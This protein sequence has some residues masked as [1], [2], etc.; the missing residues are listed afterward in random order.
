MKIKLNIKSII[1]A[2]K[3]LKKPFGKFDLN[4]EEEWITLAYAMVISNNEETYTL[5]TFKGFTGNK[6]LWNEIIKGITREFQYIGQYSE[7]QK[8]DKEEKQSDISITDVAS[9]MIAN[10]IAPDYVN[11]MRTVDIA[12]MLNAIE[13]AKKEKMESDRFWTFYV[14]APHIDMKKIKS[15]EDLITFPWEAEEKKKKRDDDFERAKKNFEK[16]I[17]SK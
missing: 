7:E 6:K 5:Q 1:T 13:E 9:M 10:G 3:L 12:D 4:N 11:E 2:E 14:M 17:K 15:P 16:F 8:E